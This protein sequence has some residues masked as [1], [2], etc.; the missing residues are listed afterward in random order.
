MGK[1]RE[2]YLDEPFLG[3]KVH[4]NEKGKFEI[5]IFGK[6]LPANNETEFKNVKQS[7]EGLEVE[8]P[9]GEKIMFPCANLFWLSEM[10][11]YGIEKGNTEKE[12]FENFS[13]N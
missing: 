9:S 13:I 1:Q 2:I 10:A 6:N 12:V 3:L 4:I 5:T 11:L 7:S 8:L